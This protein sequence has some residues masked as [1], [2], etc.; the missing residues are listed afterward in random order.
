VAERNRSPD[1]DKTQFDL[2]VA[3]LREG[4]RRAGDP[5]RAD[6]LG[7]PRQRLSNGVFCLRCLA[8]IFPTSLI[9]GGWIGILAITLAV[10]TTLRLALEEALI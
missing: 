10:V 2:I 9:V 6:A 4:S 8:I 7:L 1:D 5:T 3:R